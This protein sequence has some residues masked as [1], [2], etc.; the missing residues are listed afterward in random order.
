MLDTES[1]S[2][3][4]LCIS[5]VYLTLCSDSLANSMCFSWIRARLYKNEIKGAA[6]SL[7]TACRAA[8]V[9]VVAMLS[10][11]SL[12]LTCQSFPQD[13][14][15]AFFLGSYLVFV[16]NML[17]TSQS[18]CHF[19]SEP[20]SGQA[21]IVGILCNLTVREEIDIS[22]LVHFLYNYDDGN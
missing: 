14:A 9:A 17:K 20:R 3:R 5:A 21:F 11:L 4:R 18:I 6:L 8:A 7:S 19:S 16:Q 10:A 12:P 2:G 13:G 1:F 22:S 15:L